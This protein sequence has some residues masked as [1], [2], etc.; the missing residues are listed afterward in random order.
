MYDEAR[1]ILRREQQVGAERHV[2][3]AQPDRQTGQAQPRREPALFVIF[4]V[5]GQEAL[6]HHAQDAPTMHRHRAI[7]EPPVAHQRRADQQQR[8]PSRG[9]FGERHH[10]RVAGPLL[11]RLQ[12][13]VVERV[14]RQVEFGKDDAIHAARIRL[15][16]HRDR[17]IEVRVDIA[18]ARARRRRGDADHLV[19]VDR[20]ETLGHGGKAS[21]CGE[22][23][24][25]A[26]VRGPERSG[27]GKAIPATSRAPPPSPRA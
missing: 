8:P 22:G 17:R 25:A 1:Q 14:G 20:M 13:Q 21:R 11:R 18:D 5:I 9:P 16:R 2:V 23:G 4:A 12:V 7:V 26:T 10:R 6:R 27:H 24:L 3:L 19:G 15:P